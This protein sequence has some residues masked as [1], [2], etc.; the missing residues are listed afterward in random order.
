MPLLPTRRLA[1]FG[2]RFALV[3]GVLVLAWPL[4]ARVYRPLYCALGNVLFDGGEASAHFR[5]IATDENLDVEV[6]L[7]KRGPPLVSAVMR[8]DSNLVGYMPVVSLVALVLASPIPWRRRRRALAHGL[9]LVTVFVAARMS[10]PIRRDFSREDALAVHH[11]GAVGRWL[12][13]VSERALLDAPASFFVVPI[14]I[15]VLVALRR[16]DWA[17]VQPAREKP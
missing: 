10:I 15:W 11:P 16:E 17:L 2:L 6:R 5:P 3:Y 7:T 14:L 1:G 8:N 9:A 4:A 13:E 12:L